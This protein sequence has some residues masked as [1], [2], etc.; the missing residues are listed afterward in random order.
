MVTFLLSQFSSMT[1]SY[2]QFS[3]VTK[4]DI[5]DMDSH[6]NYY[7]FL[8]EDNW[9]DTFLAFAC[10]CSGWEPDYIINTKLFNLTQRRQVD[11]DAITIE[12]LLN[13][14]IKANLTYQFHNHYYFYYNYDVTNHI[15]QGYMVKDIYNPIRL[16]KFWTYNFNR[17][18]NKNIKVI[19]LLLLVI[20]KS[21][22]KYKQGFIEGYSQRPIEGNIVR[23]KLSRLRPHRLKFYVSEAGGGDRGLNEIIYSSMSRKK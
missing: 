11:I 23:H 16:T 12:Q 13:V 1:L 14:L 15:H 3:I 5:L 22:Y 18:I 20:K 7:T 21:K 2:F 17:T 8:R 9:L 4:I 19:Y 10:N 6:I